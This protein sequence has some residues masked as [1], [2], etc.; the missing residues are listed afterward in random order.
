MV[1]D[2]QG[3]FQSVRSYLSTIVAPI[4]YL[5][6][7]PVQTINWIGSNFTSHRDLVAE[8]AD[9]RAA[10][11]LLQAKQQRLLLL[12]NENAELRALLKSSPQI[13]NSRI[14]IAQ[15]LS[16]DSD[17][18]VQQV[19][20]NKGSRDDVYV[21]QPVL[22]ATGIV[23]Q[24]IE[25]GPIT[26][27]VL[28]ITD[29]RSAVPVQVTRSGLRAI[30]QGTGIMGNLSLA[31]IPDT[32]DIRVGDMLVTSALGQRFPAGY[33]VGRVNSVTRSSGEQF[34]IIKVTPSTKLNRSN[35]VLLLWAERPPIKTEINTLLSGKA[36][37]QSRIVKASKGKP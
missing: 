4:E 33:P 13:G 24:I 20:L 19:V 37:K 21:G 32:T 28:L 29:T 26:S 7:W 8:N 3:Q 16:V 2:H 22:D 36:P 25:V 10:I 27:R 9:L 15:L 1:L 31:H 34:A 23:G 11:M 6:N 17:P 14:E 18:F 12:E 5:V 35:W 30:A